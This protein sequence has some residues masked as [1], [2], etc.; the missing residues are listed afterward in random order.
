MKRHKDWAMENSN[1]YF[2]GDLRKNQQRRQKKD[3]LYQKKK[4]RSL[5]S[6]KPN[7]EKLQ[8][9]GTNCQML[10]IRKMRTHIYHWI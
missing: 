7:E 8:G 9:E 5:V 4:I 2:V 6:W 3:T 10:M 1:I